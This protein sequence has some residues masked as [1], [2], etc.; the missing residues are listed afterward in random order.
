MT[1]IRKV[2]PAQVTAVGDDEVEIVMSTA[3]LARDGHILLPQG[4]ILDNYRSNPIVLWQHDPEH[5]VANAENISVTTDNITARVR[6]APAGVSRKADE[7]R[8][9][10]KSGIV[11]AVSVGFDPLDGEPLDP[12]K[13]RGGQ[14]FTKWELLECSFCS[15]PVDTGAVVTARAKKDEQAVLDHY[16]EKSGMSDEASGADRGHAPVRARAVK[17]AAVPTFKRGLYDVAQLAYA[18][19]N[20]GWMVDCSKWESAI[21]GDASKVPAMLGEALTSLGEALVAMAQEEV[22]ELLAGKDLEPDE[23]AG[24][25]AL[26][27]EERARIT[28]AKT[29]AMRAWCRGLAHAK[30]RAGKVISEETAR[31]LRA[32]LDDH[33]EAISHQRSAIKLHKQAVSAVSDMMDS[34]GVPAADD[35]AGKDQD[36]QTVQK[37]GAT[38]QDEGSRSLKFRQRQAEKLRL[39]VTP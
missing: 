14:R 33:E 20:I 10:V 8:G 18:L 39:A 21:E 26:V 19:V 11:R 12:K 29:P 30:M 24:D 2:V 17:R 28:A 6:F 31:C 3:A 36:S 34:A 25:D 7:V 27:V 13:P 35:A 15:V 37:S 23:D 38:A 9:L 16:R 4:C 1:M 32:A 5:P 22:S